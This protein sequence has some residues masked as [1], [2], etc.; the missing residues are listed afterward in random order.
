MAVTERIVVLIE[1][2]EKKALE[3]SAKAAKV[4]L[5][6]VVRRRLASPAR[7]DEAAFFEALKELG[8]KA[9]QAGAQIDANLERG[10]QL[11]A[12]A[13]ARDAQVREAALAQLRVASVDR[14]QRH[15]SP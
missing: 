10:R 6:E 14:I 1:P 12:E 7:E 13:E 15:A 5:G 4:S 9:L 3:A 8:A 11:R 2:A